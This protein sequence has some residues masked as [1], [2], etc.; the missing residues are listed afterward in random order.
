LDNLITAGE[1]YLAEQINGKAVNASD[2]GQ[3]RYNTTTKLNRA[4]LLFYIFLLDHRLTGDIF[5][6]V[7]IGFL[8]V[9]I[10]QPAKETLADPIQYEAY[11]I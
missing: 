4:C 2:A 9:L 11:P 8:A 10:I 7:V 1:R 5:K 3:S 6:S